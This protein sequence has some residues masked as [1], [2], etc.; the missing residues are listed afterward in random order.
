[1]HPIPNTTPAGQRTAA[2]GN[3]GNYGRLVVVTGD[4]DTTPSR[5]FSDCG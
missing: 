1:M 5:A 4:G 3:Y 2:Y